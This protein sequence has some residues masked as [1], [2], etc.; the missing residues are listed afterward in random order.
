MT[1]LRGEKYQF[2]QQ[3]LDEI[4]NAQAH[5]GNYEKTVSKQSITI[6]LSVFLKPFCAAMTTILFRLSGF[7]VL[8]HYTATY[9]EK[10]GINF[11]PL[12]GSAIIGAVR[13][14]ASLST[15]VVL[16]FVAKKTSLAIFGLIGMVSMMSG[17]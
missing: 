12:L 5:K 8:S 10:A 9:L 6:C 14:L 4:V 13:W 17:R 16:N 11:D 15:I 1:F 7:S 2:L 3:E